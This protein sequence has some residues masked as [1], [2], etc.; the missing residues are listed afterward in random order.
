MEVFNNNKKIDVIKNTH[1]KLRELNGELDKS[2]VTAVYLTT[3]LS[4]I[5]RT[6]RPKYKCLDDSVKQRN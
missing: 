4:V 1:T 2:T 5:N 6:G 3:S